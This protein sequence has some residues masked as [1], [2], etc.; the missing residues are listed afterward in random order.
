L[1]KLVLRRTTSLPL[2]HTSTANMAGSGGAFRHKLPCDGSGPS[3]AVSQEPRR[4]SVQIC[5]AHV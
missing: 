4:D 5:V 1:R 2:A 3:P